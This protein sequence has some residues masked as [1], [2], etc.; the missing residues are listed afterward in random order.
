MTQASASFVVFPPGPTDAEAL[1]RVHVTSWR[2]TYTGLLP[3]AFLTRMSEP[4]HARR[5]E[6]TLTQPPPGEVTLA[7]ANCYGLVGYATGGPSR[8][9]PEGEAEIAVLYV[10]RASQGFGVGARL[11]R[12]TARA[13]QGQG[14]RSLVISVLRDNIR[15]RGFYEHLGGQPDAPRQE[16]GPGGALLYEVAYR[17]ADIGA[18]R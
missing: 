4:G 9:G 16:M 18:L 8:R 6:R 5:F 10:L 13:L 7:A 2:E 12:E 14:S 15:A 3:A 17:W 11:L 1:A